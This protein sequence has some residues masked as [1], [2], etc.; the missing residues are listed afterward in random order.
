MESSTLLEW[1]DIQ[2]LAFTSRGET[3]KA[4]L[5]KEAFVQ[6]TSFILWQTSLGYDFPSSGM[7]LKCHNLFKTLCWNNRIY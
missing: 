4:L 7:I 2:S 3:A 6:T 5:L 1:Y